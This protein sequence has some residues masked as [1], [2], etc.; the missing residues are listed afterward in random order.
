VVVSSS[1]L[2]QDSAG[3][4]LELQGFDDSIVRYPGLGGISNAGCLLLLVRYGAKGILD[5]PWRLALTALFLTLGLLTGFRSAFGFVAL[6]FIVAFFLEGLHR[7]RY[8]PVIAML[9]VICGSFLFVFSKNL[10][11]Q[12]QRALSFLPVNVS[13]SVKED[14]Q[15]SLDWRMF[16]TICSRATV[17]L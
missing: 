12:M 11:P 9:A 17:M 2:P 10:P 15:G 1:N 16:R 3:T 5:K 13:P 8:L 6:I 7:T 4:A 14:A